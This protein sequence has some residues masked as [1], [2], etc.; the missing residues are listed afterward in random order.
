VQ[1]YKEGPEEKRNYKLTLI[2]MKQDVAK[3]RRKTIWSMFF[4]SHGLKA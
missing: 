4:T 3:K 1:G 2:N